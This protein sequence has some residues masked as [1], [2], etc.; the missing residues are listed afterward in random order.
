MFDLPLRVWLG[1]GAIGAAIPVLWWAV[2]AR[3][4]SNR[5]LQTTTEQ[6]T[7]LRDLVLAQSGQERVVQPGLRRLADFARAFT[8]AGLISHIEKRVLQAGVSQSWPVDRVLGMKVLLAGAV[9]VIMLLQWVGNPSNVQLL[10]LALF[11]GGVAFIL[12]DFFL[13]GAA[14]TRQVEIQTGLPDFL[15]QITISVEAGL[16]FEAALGHVAGNVEGAMGMEI[17]RTLQDIRLGMSR[18]QAF[19]GLAFRTD[20]PEVKH[21]VLA[22]GQAE[23]L[24]MPIADVLR[25]QSGE[26]RLRRRQTAEE[27]AQKVGVKMIFPLVLC[28]LPALIIVL[29]APAIFE[30]IDNFPSD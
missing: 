4:H 20:V 12:P 25:I 19:E 6:R 2:S 29:L 18:Q 16:G 8:P 9:T 14:R 17:Q 1:A 22:M 3:A 28:I 21:F 10:F 26:L 27:E 13:A 30:L 24:G 7:N 11:M 15:D 23:K 5:L